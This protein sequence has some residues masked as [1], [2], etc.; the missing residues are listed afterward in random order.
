[1]KLIKQSEIKAMSSEELIALLTQIAVEVAHRAGSTTEAI[2]LNESRAVK[3][4]SNRFN[5]DE[6]KLNELLSM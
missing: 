5:L 2:R 6:E 3:E 4:L 1:M